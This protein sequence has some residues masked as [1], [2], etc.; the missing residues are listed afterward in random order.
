MTEK[1]INLVSREQKLHTYVYIY[2][3]NCKKKPSAG[4][5]SPYSLMR[6]RILSHTVGYCHT[7]QDTVTHSRILSHSA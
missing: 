5:Q 4:D 2:V 6:G 3:S 1:K 7:Q